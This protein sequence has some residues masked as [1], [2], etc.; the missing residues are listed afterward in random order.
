VQTIIPLNDDSGLR[1]TTA[2]YFTPSGTSIQARGIIPDIEV[3]AGEIKEVAAF[4]HFREK[5]LKNH[6]DT[7]GKQEVSQ[8]EDT[9]SLDEATLKDYQLM[10][11][12]DLLRGWKVFQG[13]NAA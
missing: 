12:L 4:D 13:L 6:I 5:D 1:L 9:S 2:K 7:E 3:E 10:R 11:A 8:Q